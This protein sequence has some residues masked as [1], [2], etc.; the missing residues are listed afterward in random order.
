MMEKRFKWLVC[1]FIGLIGGHF[2]TNVT[3]CLQHF[4]KWKSLYNIFDLCVILF[5]DLHVPAPIALNVVN[6]LILY[7]FSAML[8]ISA[9][10]ALDAI[11][12]RSSS[13][14]IKTLFNRSVPR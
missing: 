6:A 10:H 9:R 13:R 4:F 2:R 3:L 14:C 12:A 11:K 8:W 7:T 5:Q 1:G